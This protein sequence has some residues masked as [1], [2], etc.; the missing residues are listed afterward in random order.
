MG[1]WRS[2]G[3]YNF[4]SERGTATVS[5]G[6]VVLFLAVGLSLR[7]GHLGILVGVTRTPGELDLGYET[8]A[9][10]TFFSADLLL[11]FWRTSPKGGASGPTRNLA[12]DRINNVHYFLRIKSHFLLPLRPRAFWKT[13]EQASRCTRREQS[14][15][16]QIREPSA[17]GRKERQH[18]KI[19]CED[20]T[21]SFLLRFGGDISARASEVRTLPRGSAVCAKEALGGRIASHRMTAREGE[22]KCV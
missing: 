1:W 16:F 21:S 18:S 13:R 17:R 11:S 9:A 20:L 12:L 14:Q 22:M 15:R 7:V 8:A 6:L 10:W 2:I 5:F 19:N 4:C 3:P